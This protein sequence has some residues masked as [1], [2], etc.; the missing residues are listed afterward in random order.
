[1]STYKNIKIPF[2]KKIQVEKKIALNKHPQPSIGFCRLTDKYI[3]I[4]RNNS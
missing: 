2:L 3:I 4:R 1:M